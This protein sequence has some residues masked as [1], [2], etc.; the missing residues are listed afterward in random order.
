MSAK[1]LSKSNDMNN[2]KALYQPTSSLGIFENQHSQTITKTKQV[3]VFIMFD[4]KK[5]RKYRK[6]Q[7]PCQR[8]IA[9]IIMNS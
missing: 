3:V 2:A 7:G 1:I 5:E 8:Q 6:I 9:T 4:R